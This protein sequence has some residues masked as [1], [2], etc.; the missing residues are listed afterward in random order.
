[1]LSATEFRRA[2]EDGVYVYGLYLEGARWNKRL[3][4]LDESLPKVLFD[5][6]PYVSS[7]LYD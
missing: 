3:M 4:Y 6:M 7:I 5:Y 1:M 2:P